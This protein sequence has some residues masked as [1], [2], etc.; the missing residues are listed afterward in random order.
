MMWCG[1]G[2]LHTRQCGACDERCVVDPAAG[3]Y[4]QPSSCGD[5]TFRGQCLGTALSWCDGSGVAR[6]K[7]CAVEGKTCG[8]RDDDGSYGCVDG[9]C[10]ALDHR[11]QCNGAVAVWC[12]K[13][14]IQAR[15]CS[16]EGLICS[17]VDNDR[18]F[19]CAPKPCGDVD[20]FGR[21]TGELAEWCDG[22]GVLRTV[23]CGQHQQACGLVDEQSGY[24]CLPQACGTLD[25]HGYCDGDVA[26]WCNRDGAPESVDCAAHDQSCGYLGAAMGYH[27]LN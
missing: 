20:F 22:D 8:L 10:G 12:E 9:G 3:A 6:Q 27:C 26:T 17:W 21:C 23:D 5:L 7:D 1:T 14:E 19:D 2:G 25:F 24:H 15:D 4:C 16:D 18:G 11:G 13:D